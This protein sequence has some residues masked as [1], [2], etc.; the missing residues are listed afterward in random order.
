MKFFPFQTQGTQKKNLF[1]II[2]R[3]WDRLKKEL[4]EKNIDKIQIFLNMITD[5]LYISLRQYITFNIL[6][7]KNKFEKTINKIVVNR[8]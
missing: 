2:K 3:N 5:E 7:E 1:N 8:K 4:K 6:E